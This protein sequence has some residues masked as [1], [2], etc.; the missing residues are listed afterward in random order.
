MTWI[1]WRCRRITRKLPTVS[2]ECFHSTTNH[3]EFR[4]EAAFVLDLV[5]QDKSVQHIVATFPTKAFSGDRTDREGEMSIV[6]RRQ[7]S[8]D[9]TTSLTI[10][11]FWFVLLQYTPNV[12]STLI[13][14]LASAAISLH[15]DDGSS[16]RIIPVPLPLADVSDERA[17]E[18]G[19]DIHLISAQCAQHSGIDSE[20]TS[21]LAETSTLSSFAPSE[22][23]TL[24]G[25]RSH[26]VPLA[27]VRPTEDPYT[28]TFVPRRP[29]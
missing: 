12:T 3:A 29:L 25:N 6:S 7:L 16:P 9:F 23:A 27:S 17:D 13:V 10:D 18:K 2:D 22:L 4:S 11:S 1:G 21:R 14:Y 19:E 15:R 20:L 26:P 24:E 8:A 28:R 5:G